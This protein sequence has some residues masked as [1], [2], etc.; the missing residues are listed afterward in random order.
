M[1]TQRA[2][3]MLLTAGVSLA[4][5]ISVRHE[6]TSLMGL[7]L[8]SWLGIE[9]VRFRW[10]IQRASAPAVRCR[11]RWFDAAAP[12][13]SDR[14]TRVLQ[15]N[16]PMQVALELAPS[17]R[18]RGMRLWLEDV[19][20]PGVSAENSP[21]LVSDVGK[22]DELAWEYA[23]TPR[24]LGRLQWPGVEV[25]ITD[26]MALFEHFAFV[27]CSHEA[28]VLP[29]I[30][31]PQS[32]VSVLKKQNSQ[33]VSGQHR[34]QRPG[35]SGELLSI[36]DYQPGDP[37]KTIAWKVSARLGRLMSCEYERE[38]P[39]R[40]TIISD[41]SLYQFTGRP[42]PAAADR[43][44][45]M[46][47]SLARLLLSDRDPVASMVVN[48]DDCSWLPHGHGERQLTRM[49]HV[50]LAH[51]GR[52]TTPPGIVFEDLADV[53][54]TS[55]RHRFPQLFEPR[56]N[57]QTGFFRL[58]SGGSRIRRRQQLAFALCQ[59]QGEPLAGAH[60]LLEDRQE[61]SRACRQFLADYPS[62]RI[63]MDAPA[64]HQLAVSRHRTLRTICRVLVE[65]V[66]RAK[67]NELFMI[68]AAQP[69]MLDEIE[70]WERA[71]KMARARFHRVMLLYSDPMPE[72]L[73]IED[74][75]ARRILL[76]Q[77]RSAAQ[78][79]LQE[80]RMKMNRLGATMAEFESP[81]LAHQ[82]AAEIELLGS[83]RG[84]KAGAIHE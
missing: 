62:D 70:I 60:R 9:W 68:V 16:Q 56:I 34:Y 52:Q 14:V 4:A 22:G 74:P 31:R 53:T 79:T 61:F 65:A 41:L 6:P 11:R 83:G 13:V 81:Q 57:P 25:R 64:A 19:V 75:D 84:R 48:G 78:E 17:P 55:C 12:D 76:E 7:A 54:W 46:A 5:G 32:T 1:L 2:I 39:V 26:S 28:T 71:V 67:D 49:L 44:V 10:A 24:R 3:W 20:P 29:T 35:G 36:R 45:S 50:L 38:T 59:I 47:S 58:S 27:A 43:I 33:I 40:S 80:L 72:S 18:L 73:G 23:F 66:T 77:R 51:V 30:I 42:G 37:P 15:I 69:V 63:P 21:R 82:V 8:L